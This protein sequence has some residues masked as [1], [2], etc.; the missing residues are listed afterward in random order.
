MRSGK[1]LNDAMSC[2]MLAFHFVAQH[3]IKC[4]NIAKSNGGLSNLCNGV[5]VTLVICP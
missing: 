5:Y 2:L 1:Q 3:K 4:C